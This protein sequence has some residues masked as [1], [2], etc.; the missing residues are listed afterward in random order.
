[1]NRVGIAM[2]VA[3]LVLS[4][5]PPVRAQDGTTVRL[6]LEHG[7]FPRS[8]APEAI[9][10]VPA[11]VDGREPLSLVIF[12]HG[13]SGCVEVL[14]SSAPDA[15]C[16]P[17]DRPMQGWGLVDA[18]ARAGTRTVLLIPQLAFMERSGR[19]G[20]FGR[21]GEAARFVTESLA[22]LAP[23]FG[24]TLTLSD[25][26]SVTVL[27]HSAAF[28][29]TIAILRH[30]GLDAQLRHVV[31][32]DALYGGREVFVDWVARASVD[33]PRTLVS[34]ATGGR[35][36]RQTRALFESA[37]RRWPAQ[38][39]EVTDFASPLPAPAPRLVVTRRARVP[40]AEVP[41]RYLEE[42]LRA[43]GLPRR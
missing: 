6:E 28:E 25:V 22:Q 41:V 7:A 1:M 18:H 10:H 4:P 42:T 8:D 33:S 26:L 14:A 40:H 34:F 23:L 3:V 5:A 15:R 43:L 39:I 16:R 27:A 11:G 31:L 9:A 2:A 12:L 37:H 32:F 35:T 21:A 19:P 17:R 24:R 38:T 20:R 29:T 13:Y 36:L 30:G